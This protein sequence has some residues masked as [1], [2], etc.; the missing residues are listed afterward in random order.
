MSHTYNDLFRQLFN[1]YRQVDGGLFR[2]ISSRSNINLFL[3]TVVSFINI[4]RLFS[5]TELAS[6]FYIKAINV[7]YYAVEYYQIVIPNKTNTN[8]KI[9]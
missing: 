1:K 6:V 8:T 5:P 7:I 4:L 2:N 3:R 9:A